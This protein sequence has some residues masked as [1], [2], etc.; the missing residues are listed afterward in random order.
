MA[1]SVHAD[2]LHNMES[3]GLGTLSGGM[4]YGKFTVMTDKLQFFHT[5]WSIKR[6]MHVT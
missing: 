5:G 2:S 1:S 4:I 3:S 6:E